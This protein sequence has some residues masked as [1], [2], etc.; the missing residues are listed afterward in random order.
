MDKKFG[1]RLNQ[2][3]PSLHTIDMLLFSLAIL[4]ENLLIFL[5]PF[6]ICIRR[7]FYLIFIFSLSS[8]LLLPEKESLLRLIW[9]PLSIFIFYT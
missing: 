2:G 9:T 4:Q 6:R 3:F 7:Y 1:Q 8:M 5:S